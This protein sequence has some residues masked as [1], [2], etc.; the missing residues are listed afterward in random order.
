MIQGPIVPRNPELQL[1]ILGLLRILTT[2]LPPAGL[3]PLPIRDHL[4]NGAR[5]VQPAEVQA[6]T[7]TPGPVIVQV[8]LPDPAAAIHDLVVAQAVLPDPATAIHDPV[9]ARVVLHDRAAIQGP[10]VAL[11]V[12]HDRVVQEVLHDRAAQVVRHVHQDLAGNT[13]GFTNQ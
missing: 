8:V 4:Q 2:G 5:Q 11:A 13:D 6:R 9:V 10:A 7:L 3:L 12:P 1:S